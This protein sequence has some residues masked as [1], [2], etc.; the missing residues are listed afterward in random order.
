MLKFSQNIEIQSIHVK[1]E[2]ANIVNLDNKYFFIKSDFLFDKKDFFEPKPYD[3]NKEVTF[4]Y[5]VGPHFYLPYKNLSDFVNTMIKLLDSDFKFRINITLTFD[6]LNRGDLWDKRLNNITSFMG[7]IDNKEIMEGLFSNNTILISTSIIETLGL[8]V[9]EAIQKG[10]LSI[11]P[12]ELYAKSV[13]GNSVLTY[14]LFDCDSLADVILNLKNYS[15]SECYNLILDNQ[16]F[17]RQNEKN[18]YQNILAVFNDVL[19]KEM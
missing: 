19:K 1:K 14:N 12:N 16:K 11:V 9:I 13:Y 18:K 6:E 5:I 10:V 7:Y 2:L 3:F 17:I 4:L 15:N 8:H